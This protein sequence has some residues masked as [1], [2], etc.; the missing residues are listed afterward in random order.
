MRLIPPGAPHR[1]SSSPV[2][3]YDQPAPDELEPNEESLD[4]LVELAEPA[5]AIPSRLTD[6]QI[7]EITGLLRAGRRLPPYLFPHLF[8]TAREYELAYSG[9]AR[10]IDVLAETMA[11]PL[12]PVRT[13]GEQTD[14][15]ANMLVLGDNLQVLRRL[16]QMKEEGALRNPDGS[17]GVKLCYVDPPFASM[18]EFFGSRNEKAYA[19]RIAGAEFVEHL[20]RRLILIRELL[21]DD[22]SLFVHLDTRKVHYIKV[23]LDEIFGE[24]HFRNEII[25]QR[26]S[27]HNDTHGYGANYDSILYYSRGAEVVWNVGYHQYSDRQLARYRSTVKGERPFADFDLTQAGLRKGSSGQPWR[28]Y[29]PGAK[30][31]HWKFDLATLEQMDREGRVYWPKGGGFPRMKRYLDEARGVPLQAVWTDIPPVNSQAKERVGYPTQKPIALLDRIVSASSN[32]GDIVLDAFVGSGTTLI[33][34]QALDRR[35]IGV[36][37]GKYATYVAQARLLRQAG[38]KAPAHTFTLYNAGLYDYRSIRDLP[39]LE[40]LDFVLQL[41][42][43]RRH[44]ET[45]GG[46]PFQGFLGDDRVLVYNFKDHP[47]AKIGRPFVEDLASLCRGRLGSRCFIVA[48]ALAVEPYEDYLDVEDIRFF[49]L[50]IPYSIIAELHK[51]AFSE[52]RQPTSAAAANAPIDSFGFDFIQTPRVECRYE[53]DREDFTVGITAF[54]SDAFSAA[55]SQEDIANLAM[56]MV[57]FSYEEVFDLDAVYFAEDLAHDGWRLRIPTDKVG[58]QLMLVYVDVFGNEHREVKTPTAFAE[59]ARK[60]RARAIS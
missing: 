40:Y 10:R 23:V 31:N 43:C 17:D 50:R 29:D 4:E 35:W 5:S 15:W 51:R 8:E 33:A 13:F 11:V 36:D 24:G 25:W 2:N 58:K 39:W 53:T 59:P 20:R 55:P 48:P 60:A 14:G 28:G 46:V 52:L 34:A 19:D 37:C 38:K 41:F 54:E 57:D 47:D 12:Q 7:E 56:V 6:D 18:R 44:E 27:A 9:K 45:I 16:I 21:T 1:S 30:G 3:P 22:G 49:F 32:P 42:Q 26:T